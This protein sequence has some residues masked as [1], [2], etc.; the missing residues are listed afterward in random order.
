MHVKFNIYHNFDYLRVFLFDL[1]RFVSN[2]TDLV[3]K[4]YDMY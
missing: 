3:G 1:I 2:A 4:D